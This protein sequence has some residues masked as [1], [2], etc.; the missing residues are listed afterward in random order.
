MASASGSFFAPSPLPPPSVRPIRALYW[1][2]LSSQQQKEKT[3]PEI[4]CLQNKIEITLIPGGNGFH[5]LLRTEDMGFSVTTLSIA[6]YITCWHI[7]QR[8]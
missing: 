6:V 3:N 7:Y 8:S 4:I 5:E 2:Y 1:S